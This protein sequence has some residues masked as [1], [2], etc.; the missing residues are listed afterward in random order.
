MHNIGYSINR[1]RRLFNQWILQLSSL[2]LTTF[3]ASSVFI[4]TI[5]LPWER[6]K[7]GRGKTLIKSVLESFTQARIY[8]YT[9]FPFIKYLLNPYSG[10]TYNE[11]R[12]TPSKCL[13]VWP[14]A[15]CLPPK[16]MLFGYYIGTAHFLTVFLSAG[17]PSFPFKYI[18]TSL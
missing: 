5:I 3:S 6:S 14:E 1:L 16:S 17:M 2:F 4:G 13:T 7:G 12:M 18:L 11:D 8:T 10:I 9:S 15:L